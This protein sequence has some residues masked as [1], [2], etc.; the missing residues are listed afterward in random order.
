[1]NQRQREEPV[2]N[3]SNQFQQLVNGKSVGI[4]EFRENKLKV[5]IKM[6]IVELSFQPNDK[7]YLYLVESQAAC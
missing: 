3:P 2:A 1:M 7:L 6:I 5:K 4:E